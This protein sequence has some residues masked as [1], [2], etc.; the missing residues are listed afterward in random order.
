MSFCFSLKDTYRNGVG[1]GSG[2]PVPPRF[3]W[4]GMAEAAVYSGVDLESWKSE[5]KVL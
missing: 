4:P 5:E 1:S 2:S 3:T